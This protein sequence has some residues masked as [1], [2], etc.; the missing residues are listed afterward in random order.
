MFFFIVLC[1]LK[2]TDEC[3]K[4]SRRVPQVT[5]KPYM[6]A[7]SSPYEC[8]KCSIR[9]PQVPQTS[10]ASAPK[11]T[12]ECPKCPRRV[13]QVPQMSAPSAPKATCECPKCPRR[14]PQV[15]QM[16]APSAPVPQIRNKVVSPKGPPASGVCRASCY[17]TVSLMSL[18]W[19]YERFILLHTTSTSCLSPC[20]G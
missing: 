4:C 2:A 19:W 17:A 12:C 7:P 1:V 3:P 16:S 9:V 10:A 18:Q 11:A 8:P 13:P 15:P 20:Q 5:Q 6:S 14:V